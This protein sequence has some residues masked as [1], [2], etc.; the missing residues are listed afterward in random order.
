MGTGRAD[1]GDSQPG[2]LPPQDNYI[3]PRTANITIRDLLDE[4]SRQR[5]TDSR[6]VNINIVSNGYSHYSGV[7]DPDYTAIKL[8]MDKWFAK[9]YLN[10]TAR[11]RRLWNRV[12]AA[13]SR[14]AKLPGR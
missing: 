3:G 5:L 9:H 7:P 10:S 14:M 1:N 2:S 13:G 8:A 11:G 4:D 12:V 6:G